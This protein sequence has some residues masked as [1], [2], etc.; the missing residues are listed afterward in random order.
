M[1]PAGF[2]PAASAKMGMHQKKRTL[3]IAAIYR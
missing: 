2:E 1:D 3:A